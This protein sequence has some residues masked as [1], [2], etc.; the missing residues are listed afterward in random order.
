MLESKKNYYCNVT[1]L[2]MF[3]MDRYIDSNEKIIVRPAENFYTFHDYIYL[4][5]N[6][7]NYEKM[8]FYL[9]K[10]LKVISFLLKFRLKLSLRFF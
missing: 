7:S 10:I 6:Y 3:E 4:A 2:K 5:T 9:L 1:D 8:S